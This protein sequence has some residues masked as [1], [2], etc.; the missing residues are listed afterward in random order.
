M[1]CQLFVPGGPGKSV[2]SWGKGRCVVGWILLGD[3]RREG[4]AGFRRWRRRLCHAGFHGCRGAGWY[5]RGRSDG[6]RRDARRPAG[7]RRWWGLRTLAGGG[8]RRR[9]RGGGDG[10]RDG[11][12]DGASGVDRFAVY[13]QDRRRALK[14]RIFDDST[15]SVPR[16]FLNVL[17]RS[18]PPKAYV[19]GKTYPDHRIHSVSWLCGSAFGAM[20][21][22]G[23]TTIPT[24][25]SRVRSGP[26]QS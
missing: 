9:S 13:H 10:D 17:R 8:R 19:V 23:P 7:R 16:V 11:G 26:C 1:A 3:R 6:R 4:G 18:V 15:A 14:R 22:E 20:S 12:D 24:P 25:K 21:C 2:V 5:R